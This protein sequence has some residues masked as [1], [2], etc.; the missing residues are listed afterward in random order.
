VLFYSTT[1]WAKSAAGFCQQVAAWV[2]DMF[3]NVYLVKTNKNGHNSTTT[4]ARETNKLIFGI[5]RIFLVYV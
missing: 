3:W 2:P 5:L 4:E 1:N